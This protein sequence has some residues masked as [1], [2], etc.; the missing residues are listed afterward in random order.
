MFNLNNTTLCAVTRESILNGFFK[1]C[2][3]S[4]I[5]PRVIQ[6]GN[7]Y[8]YDVEAQVRTNENDGN[9]SYELTGGFATGLVQKLSLLP[10][11]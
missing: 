9:I 7:Q 1:L 2:L 8:T 6:L 5:S 11:I 10:G 4:F 3:K